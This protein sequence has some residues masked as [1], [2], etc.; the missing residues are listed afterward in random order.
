MSKRQNSYIDLKTNGRLFPSWILKNFSKYKLPDIMKKDDVDPCVRPDEKLEMR[1]Y[2]EFLTKYLDYNSPY[3]D[4]L[5]YHGLGSGKTATAINI[6]NMLYNY[7][8]GWNVFVLL[9]ATL[10]DYPWLSDLNVWLSKEEKEFRMRNIIFIS[11]DSPIADKQFLEAMKNSDSSKKSMY[12]IEEAHNFIRNVYSNINSKQGK[13]AQ[14]VYDYIINDKKDNEGVR[15]VL[16]S[17]TPAINTPYELALIFNLLRP[18]IFP[19]SEA[20]FNQIYVSSSGYQK[21]NDSHKNMFQRRIL[22][23]VSYYYG[24]TPDVYASK[25]L[26]YLDIPMSDYQSE[27]YTHFEEVEAAMARQN[28]SKKGS[29]QKYMSY[30]RQS[31]NFVFPQVN[32]W[33]TG[34]GRPRPNKFKVSESE[35]DLMEKARD[36]KGGEIDKNANA[37]KYLNELNKY[38]DAFDDYLD[39]I[40]IGDKSKGYTINDDIEKFHKEYNDDYELFHKKNENKSKMYEAL[41][42]SSSKFLYVI[43]NILKSKGP[44]LVYSNYVL[45]EGLQIFKVYLK[46]FGF[47]SYKDEKSKDNYRYTEYHGGID[48][49]D[50]KNNLVGFNLKENIYGKIIKI[51]MI[52]A[53]GAEGLSL[54]NTRQVHI[55]E[56]YWHEV[57]ITQ[58]TGRAIRQCSHKDLPL[59]ERHVDVY[60][61]KS[62]R[63]KIKK[64][65][66]DQFIEDIARSKEGLIQSFLDAVK[67]AAIDCVLNKAHNMLTQEYKCFQFDELSLFESQ[68]GPAYKE[69]VY[70]DMKYNSGSNDMNAVTLKIKVM[71]IKAIIQLTSDDNDPKFSNPKSYWYS[72]EYGTVYDFDLHHAIG[73]VAIDD[74]NLPK[75]LDNET[76]IIDKLVPIPYFNDE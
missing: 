66:A 25:M 75:K 18:N 13:R 20:T 29:M 4:I 43:F 35:A 72:N 41:Y 30:T 37:K 38:V 6:Y 22:G 49:K 2:Q 36:K 45:V 60:R 40:N 23:L 64:W 44:V 55:I 59:S 11:Y 53:A 68:I 39:G 31:C 65:T 8:P 67:E 9:K 69:D 70:D 52:S 61:Y 3:R 7:N 14:V 42:K 50:R 33:V 27:I 26:H 21:L 12:I 62:I 46:Y 74:N 71:K 16:L 34:E 1:K 56:P 24:S 63:P 17:G 76:Y 54:K 10:K 28:K 32:Q 5:V 47:G 15:V 73:K 57:R 19:K 51:I 48:E 58:M